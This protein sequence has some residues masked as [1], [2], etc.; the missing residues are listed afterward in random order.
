MSKITPEE[1]QTNLSNTGDVL[2][3]HNEWECDIYS[4]SGG[5]RIKPKR[6]L[7]DGKEYETTSEVCSVPYND[8]GHEYTGTS[9]HYF[10]KE[11]VFGIE[12]DFDLNTIVGKTEV[13]VLE[14]D[15]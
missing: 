12:M 5:T 4:I 2:R 13:L 1:S 8:M 10:I 9:R 3:Y 15:V 11:T 7:V 14:Y 6:V